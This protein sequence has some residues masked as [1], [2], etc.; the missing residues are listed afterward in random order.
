MAITE[1][2]VRAKIT[3]GSLIIETPYVLSFSVTRNRGN[4][5]TMNTTLKIKGNLVGTANGTVVVRA[6]IKGRLKTIFT[7]D[8]RNISVSPCWDDP[9]YISLS[10]EASDILARLADTKFTRRQNSEAHSY[11]LIT[12]ASASFKSDRFN[13]VTEAT[14]FQQAEVEAASG[15]TAPGHAGLPAT[16]KESSDHSTSANPIGAEWSSA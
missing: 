12:S 11:A 6:G 14:K 4:P 2:P 9:S 15:P 5:S 10:V 1:V 16:G 13:T 8:I 3:I 7:G